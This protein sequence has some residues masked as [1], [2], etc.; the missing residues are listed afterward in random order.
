MKKTLLFLAFFVMVGINGF[1]Q[2]AVANPVPDIVQCNNEVFD[3]TVQ[4]P[5]AL[6]NQSPNEFEVTYFLSYEDAE[7]NT[8]AIANPQAFIITTGN[9]EQA[10]YLR[11]T[12]SVIDSYDITSFVV[13][14]WDGPILPVFNDVWSCGPYTLPVLEGGATYYTGPDGTGTQLAAGTVITDTQTIYVYIQQGTCSGSSSFTITIGDF[15][16]TILDV[17]T[18]CDIEGTGT[19]EF[20]LE[21]YYGILYN[22]YAGALNINVYETYTDAVNQTNPISNIN[23]YM[24]DTTTTQPHSV[25]F[26]VETSTACVV[27]VELPLEVI[28]C[29]NISVSGHVAYDVDG[30]GCSETDPGAS[31]ILVSYNLG[32]HLDYAYTDS[33]GNYTFYNVPEGVITVY[34]NTFYP[35]NMVATP[36]SRLV[37]IIDVNVE[38]IDFCLSPPVPVNDMAIY[39]TPTSAAQPGFIAT[40]ALVI[41]NF[42]TTPASC[43]ATLQF[44]DTQ[45]DFIQ[46]SPSMTQTGNTLTF[47]YNNIQPYG[48]QVIYLEFAVAMPGIV[49]LGDIITFTGTVAIT[50]GND[51]NMTNNTYVLEQISVNSWDPND[52]NVREGEHITEAQAD[53][54]LHYIIRFQNMGNANAHNVKILTT[55][56]DNL[57]WSTFEPMIASHSF[58]TNRGNGNEVEFRFNNIQLAGSQVNESQSHGFVQYRI[59]PNANIQIGDT[60]SGQAGIYFDFNPVVD[61]NTIT[62]TVMSTAGVNDPDE[63]GFVMYPN[64]AS[65]NIAIS[66]QNM[67]RAEVQLTDVLGKTVMKTT[68]DATMQSVDVS[69]LKTGIYFVTLNA[70][71]RKY[72]QKLLIK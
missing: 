62:T 71:G 25:Y 46:A 35:N 50:G 58:Q 22:S 37:D 20:D 42:G 26:R 40:Y 70:D 63:K 23:D 2:Q 65:S 41:N 11:V 39:I 5:I 53:G 60:M 68:I 16:E 59:K 15:N 55:L 9:I 3:L 69:S 49:D 4:A 61:T 21:P 12:S 30:N 13:G 51:V 38:N 57:D 18:G 67:D 43:T 52:I 33:E 36:S 29:S 27:I 19:A 14:F 56:D 28:Q 34:V 10:L 1:A 32:N 48:Y 66:M 8:N 44:N 54:Y 72:T 64:P 45:L 17:A 31:G 7:N 6:A 24:P 47:A